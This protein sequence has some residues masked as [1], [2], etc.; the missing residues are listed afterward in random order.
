MKPKPSAITGWLR[1]PASWLS[2]IAALVSL[3]TFFLVYADRGHLTV[4]LPDRVAIA[5]QSHG[6]ALVIPLVFTNT[7]ASR[8]H[9]HVIESS[10]VLVFVASGEAQQR[11][12]PLRWE[13]EA[14]F[15]STN[16]FHRR[17][18][19]LPYAKDDELVDQIDYVNR[20]FPFHLGGGTSLVKIYQFEPSD[21]QRL[22]EIGP[23]EIRVRVRTESET[24]DV[25]GNYRG[26]G[27]LNERYS[28]CL[29]Q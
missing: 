9:R 13:F 3:S 22:A 23:F 12:M 18:P 27:A 16:E 1:E 20:A 28:F 25:S 6:L 19:Q 21:S 7:G 15:V 10:A 5:D 11:T 29:R 2:L 26:P 4:L 24:V 8:T 17:Y 14:Q